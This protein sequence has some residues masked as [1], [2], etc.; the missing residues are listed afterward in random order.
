MDQIRAAADHVLRRARG[1]FA[2]REVPPGDLRPNEIRLLEAVRSAVSP[3]GVTLCEGRGAIGRIAGGVVVP[4]SNP[5]M[6]AGVDLVSADTA[7]LYPLLLALD[8]GQDPSEDLRRG[9]L[10]TVGTVAAEK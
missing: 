2:R 10:E 7:W 4:R 8:M 3:V 1:V 6:E 5:A 9:W